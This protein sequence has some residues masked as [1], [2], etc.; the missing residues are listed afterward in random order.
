MKS[1]K[2]LILIS[3]TVK[4][5]YNQTSFTCQS[6]QPNQASDC[7]SQTTNSGNFCCFIK[8]LSNSEHR[9]I[10]IPSDSFNGQTT[11][12]NRNKSY[13]LNCNQSTSL[14]QKSIL[15]SCGLGN[16]TKTSQ[17][18]VYS[19]LIN[20]C[21]YHK[22]DNQTQEGCFW[23]G[24]KYSGSANWGGLNLD[25]RGKFLSISILLIFLYLIVFL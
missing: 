10:S 23:L 1:Y 17:C 20:S 12:T 19:S 15:L 21:C 3:I 14:S 8:S 16:E 11:Y 22:K 9:C 7:F 2:I 18:Q 5:I 25:C 4:L 24:S 6:T 13:L